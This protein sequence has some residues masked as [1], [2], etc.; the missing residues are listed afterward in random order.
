VCFPFDLHTK[1]FKRE[2]EEIKFHVKKGRWV[3]VVWW[4]WYE[5][6]VNILVC[7]TFFWSVAR[8]VDGGIKKKIIKDLVKF[9][10]CSFFYLK[11]SP[12]GAWRHAPF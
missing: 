3:I 2:K 6:N 8:R 11:F 12:S 9:F 5:T 4:L 1:T 10:A 7:V